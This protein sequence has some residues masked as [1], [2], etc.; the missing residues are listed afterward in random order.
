MEKLFIDLGPNSYEIIIEKGLLDCLGNEISQI[1]KN[2]KIAIVT[3]ENV[4]KL[5]G[6]QLK[7]TLN[8]YD[9]HFIVVEPGEKSKSMET[10]KMVYDS[11]IDFNLTRGDLIIA[12]GGGVVG[13][14]AGFAASTYLRGV[15]YIQIPTSFLAQIDS[16]V[17]GKVAIN[18]EQGK[19]LV[20]SFY[21]PKKVFIDTSLLS[22]LSDKYVK[23]GLG[24]V[25]KYACIKDDEFLE[26]LM[27]IKSR[28]QL[29][30]NIEYII[31]KCCSIKADLVMEDER[32]K[33]L[34]M[35][36]NFGHTFGHAIE[37]HLNYRYSHG[38]AV[39]IGMYYITKKS[40]ELGYTEQTTSE[41]IKELLMNFNIEYKID[42]LDMDIIRETIL[43]DKKNISGRINLILLK[44]IGEA[45]IERIE[46]EE[47]NKFF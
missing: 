6:K 28:D 22:S 7:V 11:F 25:I 26:F 45:F 38:E 19:N 21:H 15:D 35:L 30:Q 47:I 39:A 34:R 16:S 23:D 27:A 3:D 12:F 29:F 31:H 10:L 4:F 5:Y 2:H 46:I 20:G 41:K 24:E 42:D 9:T 14:L 43:L 13:D 40:V 1:Y 8:K 44:R 36:L 32:D 33:G 37:K 17:G 18:L